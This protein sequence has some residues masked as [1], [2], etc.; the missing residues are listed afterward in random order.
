MISTEIHIVRQESATDAERAAAA[1]GDD[2]LRFLYT[3]VAKDQ[4]CVQF[5]ES[6][7]IGFNIVE[8]IWVEKPDEPVEKPEEPEEPKEIDAADETDEADSEVSTA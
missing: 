3:P 7:F 2:V 8:G 1:R 6:Q 5:G 4:I